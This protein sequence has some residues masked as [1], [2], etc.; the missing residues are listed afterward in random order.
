VVSTKWSERAKRGQLTLQSWALVGF[1][2][3]DICE[4]CQVPLQFIR[5]NLV[6]R[7][8]INGESISHFDPVDQTN[9]TARID[10]FGRYSGRC[11]KR[12]QDPRCGRGNTSRNVPLCRRQSPE[13]TI[14]TVDLCLQK[15]DAV[16]SCQMTSKPHSR[17]RFQPLNQQRVVWR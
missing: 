4:P 14:A 3:S 5:P 6:S 11:R 17:I 2:M 16:V 7:S 8:A 13:S 1:R 9:S 15:K 12:T 10:N